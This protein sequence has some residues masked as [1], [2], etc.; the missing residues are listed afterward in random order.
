MS[1]ASRPRYVIA[2]ILAV[3]VFAAPFLIVPVQASPGDSYSGPYFG[4]GNLPPGCIADM[5]KP[6]P[7]NICHHMRTD[8]NALDS[9]QVDVLVMVPVS[10]TAER[11]MRIMRQS[12]EM[13]EAGIDH[14]ARE[15]GLDWLADGMDFHITVDHFDPA[16]GGGE[17][18]TYPIV[19]PEIV[20]IATNPVGGAGIGIDPV[21]FPTVLQFTNEDEIPCH[22]VENP[23][24]FDYWENLPG[25]DSHHE[26]RSGTYVE[27][28]E[29]KGGNI[30]FAINGAV[31]PD[32][33][34][35]DF[36]GLFD[37][38]SH[39]FGHC[40]TVGHVGD[41][42]EGAWNVTPI[43]DIMAY[44]NAPTHRTKC[45]STLD[46]EG[47]AL[48][49]SRYLDVNSDGSVAN[50]DRLVAN[51]PLGASDPSGLN[52]PF[53][54]QH[55]H[56]HLYASSSGDPYDCPQPDVGLVP[57]PRTDWTPES[58]EDDFDGD[59]IPDASDNCA[60]IAN[61]GQED[62]DGD[63]RG[64]TCQAGPRTLYMDG[65][66]P[67]GEFDQS[68]RIPTAEGDYL[69]LNASPGS[70]QESMMI[71]N[72]AGNRSC[73]GNALF[74]V[75]T[76][77]L[78]GRVAGDMQITFPAI[79]N[80]GVVEIR[81]WPDLT[82]MRCNADYPQPAGTVVTAL[83]TGQGTVQ[84]TIPDLDFVAGSSM[85]MQI[86]PADASVPGYGR[87]LYGTSA[88]KVTF[89]LIPDSDFDDDGL[90]DAAD[91][92]PR[93]AN[94]GQEDSDGDGRGD[95]CERIERDGD[96][97]GIP[98]ASDNCVDVANPGQED[99]DG[100][101]IGDAC[102]TSDRPPCEGI[103]DQEA[104]PESTFF[105]HKSGAP[106]SE[107]NEVDSA[108]D[109][110]IF[111]T[112]AP[113]GSISALSSDFPGLGGESA[114][115]PERP[116]DAAWTGQVDGRIRC[117]TFDLFQK[118]YIGE[119][120]FGTADY[121]VR[122][123][124]GRGS[125]STVYQLEDLSAP[126]SDQAV[127]HIRGSLTKMFVDHDGN[128]ATA[129]VLGDL[130]IDPGNKP[131]TIML[132]DTWLFGPASILYDS[133]EHPSGFVVNE[134][135]E[136]TRQ[137][138][139]TTVMFTDNSAD[140][141]QFSDDATI[142]ARLVDDVGAPIE[143]AELVFELTGENGVE[144]WTAETDAD[145]VASTTRTLTGAP[146]TYNLTVNYAGETDVYNPDSD[147]KFF[148]ID[149][150]TSVTT[151]VVAG[152]GSKRTLTATLAEDDGP[153]LGGQEIVFFANGT[154]IGRATT[155]AD[156]VATLSAPPDY[157]GGRFNFEASFAGTDYYSSSSGSYQT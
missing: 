156:G 129:A 3:I 104:R 122:V 118:N 18:T 78:D 33:T 113:T 58:N 98:N 21:D 66:T 121:Q 91:N 105:F 28:C 147:Q 88:S 151:L 85:M 6:P 75:F 63:G 71:Q 130:S 37:L 141:G 2:L 77:R 62:A 72:R 64:D 128:S 41:G 137:A 133:T 10:A 51:D 35:F 125:D 111:D 148:T 20:V 138:A 13:W 22:N 30:C 24:D 29:G 23:F 65:R 89:D 5:T 68:P 157:R 103:S 43:H 79:A 57:G 4:A 108:Q 145:G 31:D 144:G 61:P 139:D 90:E 49:M 8:L 123:I 150:E 53:Q 86:T 134:G 9:P 87:A 114:D 93:A 45:V 101:G 32:P 11:D 120:L 54:V 7:E 50:S 140:A 19:D 27:D 135:L 142:A 109:G 99:T 46:V 149:K 81:V 59:G 16:G 100:D 143:G 131:V 56:D 102:E 83:P 119:G 15:M 38:V 97:D 34:R 115:M 40:L 44:N 14:L 69:E 60:S 39:E 110:A 95:A 132:R 17:F 48:R 25:F 96:A 112:N 154:E 136:E 67:V 92:C 117:L 55:P 82:S 26:E 124:V 94:A 73:A 74:P 52:G 116:I 84:A 12:V 1:I 80:G 126:G 70:S 106:G 127:T 146:G 107:L 152:K 42:G 153:K 155:N 36:F 47:V 76:G